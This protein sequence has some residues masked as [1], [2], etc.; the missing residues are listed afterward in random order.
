[1][2]LSADIELAQHW[3]V[4]ISLAIRLCGIQARLTQILLLLNALYLLRAGE[5][6]I[7]DVQGGG[8]PDPLVLPHPLSCAPPGAATSPSPCKRNTATGY[9][10]NKTKLWQNIELAVLKPFTASAHRKLQ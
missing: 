6:G 4:S 5:E 10:D 2:E 9:V 7:S 3:F 8:V 1:M